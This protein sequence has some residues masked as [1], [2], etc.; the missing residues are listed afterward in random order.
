MLRAKRT[1]R[2]KFP[3]SDN[4][5]ATFLPFHYW[6]YITLRGPTPNQANIENVGVK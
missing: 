5:N 6:V 3:E 2:I 1:I 4:P